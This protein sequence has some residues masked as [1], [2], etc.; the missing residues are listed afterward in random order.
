[1][2]ATVTLNLPTGMQI[3]LAL[4][5]PDDTLKPFGIRSLRSAMT[6]SAGMGYI[7]AIPISTATGR[8]PAVLVA[9][10]TIA[11]MTLWAAMAR[12]FYQ[13]MAA[14]CFQGI[15]GGA[16]FALAILIIVDATFIHERPY[17]FAVFWAFGAFFVNCLH[18][19]LPFFLKPSVRWRPVYLAWFGGCLAIFILAYSFIPETYFIR[20]A[21]A[22]NGRILVQSSTEKVHI[23][24]NWE[25]VPCGP[26]CPHNHDD[27]PGPSDWA[28]RRRIERAPGTKWESA[29]VVYAQMLLCM[30][31]PLLVWVSLLSATILSGVIFNTLMIEEYFEYTLPPDEVRMSGVYRGAAAIIGSVLAIPASGPLIGLSIR[32]FTLRSGGT[33]HAEVYLPGFVL[34]VLSSALSQSL[35]AMGSSSGGPAVLFYVS[36]GL[37][38]FSYVSGE[39]AVVL[40]IIE[41]FPPWASA[42]LA[43]QYFVRDMVA[44]GIGINLMAWVKK[45]VNVQSSLVILVLI[46]VIGTFAVPIVFWGKTVRQYI[47]GRWSESTKGG[48]RPR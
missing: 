19:A 24:D 18:M 36:Y 1:M 5:F 8:R 22:L 15:A 12:D 10:A 47:H 39:V 13:L 16:T 46:L 9:S 34:P 14:T 29:W 42:S 32:Y 33:R 25:A 3:G 26:D 40:W 21:V 2:T 44:F 6:F 37:C 48:I 20:P 35:L 41:A 11:L 31:N 23:Y 4:E 7:V 28:M 45:D 43:V 38:M 30:C 27:I 17:A